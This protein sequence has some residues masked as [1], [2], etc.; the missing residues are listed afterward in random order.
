[1]GG[2]GG[3]HEFFI[4]HGLRLVFRAQ[5]ALFAHHC[6]FFLELFF[7]K[8]QVLHTLRFQPEAYR[9]AGLFQS[10]EIS[11]VVTAGEGIL[12]AALGSNDA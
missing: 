5:A 3:C 12:A 6:G 4:C 10:L 2:I 7:V 8:L 1:M 9:Q 11:R